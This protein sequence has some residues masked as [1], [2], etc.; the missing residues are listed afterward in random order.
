MGGILSIGDDLGDFAKFLVVKES[1]GDF[2][3]FRVDR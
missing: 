2:V 3:S 1:L